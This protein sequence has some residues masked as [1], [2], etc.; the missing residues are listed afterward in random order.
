MKW[1]YTILIYIKLTSHWSIKKGIVYHCIFQ[2]IR[3]RS[4]LYNIFKTTK[5]IK[6]QKQE[7]CIIIVQLAVLHICILA[8]TEVCMRCLS[9]TFS[10]LYHTKM[11]MCSQYSRL[12]GSPGAHCMTV[13]FSV[14]IY[15]HLVT[16]GNVPEVRSAKSNSAG[17]T[18]RRPHTSFHTWTE[19]FTH[20]T[21]HCAWSVWTPASHCKHKSGIGASLF[22]AHL[23]GFFTFC[24]R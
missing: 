7:T 6:Q 5:S 17:D 11:M 16:G 24:W 10:F 9:M 20:H 15:L 18:Q 21:D 19:I 4:R 8:F 3:P 2:A 14:S 12:S 13:H 22:P 1:I 23:F